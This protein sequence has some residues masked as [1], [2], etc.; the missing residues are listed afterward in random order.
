V[1]LVTFVFE[2]NKAAAIEKKTMGRYANERTGTC[3]AAYAFLPVGLHS[4]NPREM[5]R[6]LQAN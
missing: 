1:R 3:H 2:R 5:Q 4:L 6:Q